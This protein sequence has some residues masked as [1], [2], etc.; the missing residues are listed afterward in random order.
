[1]PAAVHNKSKILWGFIFLVNLVSLLAFGLR[2][3]FNFFIMF[4][5]SLI[6][7]FLLIFGWGRQPERIN[8]GMYLLFYTVCGSIPLLG[9][10][11]RFKM[12][13]GRLDF[14]FLS[15]NRNKV[16]KRFRGLTLFLVLGFLIKVPL[17]G[18]HKWL[19]KAHVEAPV[20]GSMIL[21]RVLL[22]LGGYGLIRIGYFLNLNFSLSHYFFYWVIFRRI[23]VGFICFRRI[24]LKIFVAYS[25][26]THMAVGLAGLCNLKTIGIEGAILMFIAHGFCSSGLFFFIKSFYQESGSRKIALNGGFLFVN[27]VMILFWGSLCFFNGS[28]PPS[29]KFFCELFLLT[30]IFNQMSLGFSFVVA[31]VF[32]NGL[33]K[34]IL[35]VVASHAKWSKNKNFF[36]NFELRRSLLCLFHLVY[37][38]ALPLAVL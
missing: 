35:Y 14:I 34:V 23:I 2:E 18:G 30:N 20:V 5:L 29:L 11:I 22:K 28:L 6:P 9:C 27:R 1:M 37:V 10:L 26:I 24:D 21:A 4:E 16:C 8:A 7:M 17:F 32:I 25:S 13:L 36:L 31:I 33:F 3:F 38:L 19:T 12:D 15:L